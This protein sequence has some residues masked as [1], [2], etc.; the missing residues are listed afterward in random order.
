MKLRTPPRKILV[1]RRKGLGDALV[2]L[3]AVWQLAAA[4]GGARLDL[5]IDR[6]F[7]PLLADLAQGL[8]V[9]PWPPSPPSRQP[10]WTLLR[11][12]NYDLVLDY[13]GSPRTALWTALSGA[14]L[15]VGYDL[16]RRRWAYNLRVPRNRR[17]DQPVVQF[18][19]EAF[20]DPLRALGFD[21][22]PWRPGAAS[23]FSSRGLGDRYRDWLATLPTDGR[24]LAA[25]VFSATWAAKAWPAREAAALWRS[26]DGAGVVPVLICGPGDE[27]LATA[28]RAEAPQ[29][30]FAPPT[31]LPELAHLLSRCAVC[32]G[33][34]NGPRH[35]AALLG[36]PTVTLFGPTD[37]RGWNPAD[38]R[39][40]AV[41]RGVP[42]APCD[43]TVCPVAGHP[44]LD[45]LPAGEVAPV[46]QRLLAA[47]AR[48]P[49]RGS[50]LENEETS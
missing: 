26:L 44:C 14:P 32:V 20:L 36:V 41:T 31:T 42:C 33:T 45:D 1:I 21:P 10:W 49:A 17:E 27:A 13:L 15:R 9:L 30:R 28:L 8:R 3:P 2:T 18:A 19:G 38:P 37:P 29:A 4:F 40:V 50:G 34:D 6:P 43:L 25:L 5:V 48:R 11:A 47:T 35:L 46:V 7:V 23:S 24:P 39:H 16:P 12:E 22:P